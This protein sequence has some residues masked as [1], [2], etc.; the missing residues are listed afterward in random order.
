M[1]HLTFLY[2]LNKKIAV[3]IL[4]VKDEL[5]AVAFGQ[6]PFPREDIFKIFDAKI[7]REIVAF[8]GSPDG[9]VKGRI[10]A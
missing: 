1:K 7:Q 10:G 4:D 8:V 5:S 9:L 6:E 2:P 3:K